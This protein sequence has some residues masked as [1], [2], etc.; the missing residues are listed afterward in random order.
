MT[1]PK[2]YSPETLGQRWG[3]SAEKIRTMYRNGE[4]PGFRLGKL[5]RF[6][7]DEVERYECQNTPSLCTE[8][9]GLS[10][11]PHQMDDDAGSRLVRMT[12]G[13]PSISLVKSGPVSQPREANG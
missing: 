8:E 5:I 10:L 7:A 12:V 11:S 9:S 6:R 1:A 2:A 3:C 13:V 4:L